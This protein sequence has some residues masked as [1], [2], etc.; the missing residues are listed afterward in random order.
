MKKLFAIALMMAL[1]MTANAQDVYSVGYY[2][3]ANGT[4]AALYKN[5][6]RL[7]TAQ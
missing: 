1:A 2:D 3:E 7:Y 5:G 4:V 6:N